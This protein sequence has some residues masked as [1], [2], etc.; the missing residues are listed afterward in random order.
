MKLKI[1]KFEKLGINIIQII[2]EKVI[3]YI[4]SKIEKEKKS[5]I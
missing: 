5:L 2:D 3:N 4:S 1:E